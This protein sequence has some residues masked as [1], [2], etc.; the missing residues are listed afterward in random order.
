MQKI[1]KMTDREKL[2]AM[3]DMIAE[4]YLMEAKHDLGALV[5]KTLDDQQEKKRKKK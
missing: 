3:V 5:S 1:S 2:H 4:P